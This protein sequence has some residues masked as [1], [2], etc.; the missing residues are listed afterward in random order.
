MRH[1]AWRARAPGWRALGLAPMLALPLLVP[2]S[3]R[4][5]TVAVVG[6][7]W[8]GSA[9]TV[10]IIARAGGAILRPGGLG[11]VVVARSDLPDFVARLYAAG[12]WLVLDP[13][14]AGGCA[15]PAPSRP[16][17]SLASGEP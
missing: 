13:A 9:G 17:S 7:P 2:L 3:P 16:P 5:G 15:P 11:N 14:G 4:A 10:A 8:G 12:A 1:F 6:A